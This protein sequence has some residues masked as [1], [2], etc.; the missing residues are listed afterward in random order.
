MINV[1]NIERFATHDGPGIRTTIFLKG[2]SLHC[3]WC[4]N[5][6]TWVE[7]P[8]LMHDT[9]KCVRCFACQKNC[10]NMAIHFDPEFK[11]NPQTCQHCNTCVENC[12][13][14][15]LEFSGKSM[16]IEEIVKIVLKDIDYYKNSQGGVTISGGEAFVQFDALMELLKTL[17]KHDLHVAIETTG[18]YS[19]ERIKRALSHIDLWLIDF[20][21]IDKEM[22]QKVTGGDYDQIMEN[23]TYLMNTCPD[24]VIIRT[25]VIP[26]FN[27]DQ[28]TLCAMIEYVSKYPVKEMDLLPYH[29]LGKS[30]WDK[31]HKKYMY[32][33]LKMMDKSELLDYV[34]I[35]KKHGLKIK[36]GG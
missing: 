2:C 23:I 36:L 22:L 8:V 12:P 11:W 6:E 4:A 19:N 29:S 1:S 32:S 15:A 17:K 3:P 25:P 31:M 24:Q 35:G 7:Y 18:N 5:P 30:K 33:D 21:H 28:K 27:A 13:L 20:K 26:K 16:E 14:E 9:K 10:P 34:E